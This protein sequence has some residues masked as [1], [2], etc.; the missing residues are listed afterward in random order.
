[1]K[2][3]LLSVMSLSL[4]A[5]GAWGAE[6]SHPVP[7]WDRARFQIGAYCLNP[8]EIRTRPVI[9]GVRECGIDFLIGIPA[10]DVRALDICAEEGVGVVVNGVF[11]GWWGGDGSRAGKMKETCPLEKYRK[12]AARF[13]RH[14]AI[15][16]VDIGDEPSALDF[17]HY[18]AVVES[19]R[20]WAPGLP[21]YLNL[22]PNYA[23]VAANTGKQTRN[24]LG[25]ATY[26]EHIARYAEQVPLSYLSYDFY[27][28]MD[29]DAANDRFRLKMWDNFRIVAD[30]CRA[31][32]RDFWYIP[33]VNSH[34]A[35]IH[36]TENTLRF[37]AHAAL[38]FGAVSITWAC[39]T[40]GWWTNNV[41]RADGTPNPEYG[42]LKTVNAELRRL[43][44]VFMRYRN[45]ATHFVGFAPE[46][47]LDTIGIAVRPSLDA[48]G[49]A[50]VKAADGAPLVVGEM[51][52]REKGRPGALFVLVA[53]D[54]YDRHPAVR[55]VRF[56]AP[57]GRR[58][59]AWNGA[60]EAKV[61]DEGAGVFSVAV[62]SCGAVLLS[63]E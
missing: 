33:Q 4:L 39:Y 21:L 35:R 50:D 9:R 34:Y 36:M 46:E 43:G 55:T 38:A 41:L 19:L 62:Q 26:A 60:G 29:N 20:T 58:V 56:R 47:H 44:D 8:P 37:Q 63:A 3:E 16:A 52:A 13:V 12:A 6:T 7:A 18:R 14:P 22:Y 11:P 15:V 23:S 30:S 24:Q 57:S 32:G 25:T 42:R 45:V 53:D 59:R 10:D 28:Y 5:L 40:P 1:M 48:A 17:P 27:P 49:F 31:T 2:K 54:M 51:A 61:R